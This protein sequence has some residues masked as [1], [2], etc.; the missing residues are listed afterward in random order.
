[1]AN[2]EGEAKPVVNPSKIF[3]AFEWSGEKAPEGLH[4]AALARIALMEYLETGKLLRPPERLDRDYDSSGGAWVSLRSQSNIHLRHARDGFWHF[5]GEPRWSA[6]EDI[7]RAALLTAKLLPAGKIGLERLASSHI[8][9][10]SFSALEECTL[11]QLD[12]DRYGI[13]VCS[14]ERSAVMGGALPRMPGIGNEFQ[15]FQ[16]ARIANGK[17]LAIEPYRIYRHGV[18]KAVEPGI[19]W[20]KT[21]VPKADR[22]AAW[23]NPE[24]CARIAQ[25]ARDIAI[26]YLLGLPETMTPLPDSSMLEGLH[27]LFVT[28]YIWGRLRG[29]MGDAITHLDADL[30]RLVLAALTDERFPKLEASAPEAVAVS[31]SLLTNPITLGE[32]SPET[33][34]RRSVH[35]MQALRVYQ[36]Q[37]EGM[38]LPFLAAMHDLNPVSYAL[39][40]ID[41]AG[42]TRPPY[43][44]QRFDCATW[45]AD[46]EG[47]G[48]MEGAFRR[49]GHQGDPDILLPELAALYSNYIVKHQKPDG[50]FHESYEP[51]R[52][53]LHDGFTPRLASS[54][55]ETG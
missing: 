54:V 35:G 45:L 49:I 14:R 47:A 8:A 52:N 5:P 55:L 1:M 33:V 9:V 7:A 22:P 40:V 26:S 2:M 13:V 24:L 51:F 28:I 53:R 38:L 12:N 18:N 31:I 15:Q 39:E 36:N 48:L 29:C 10:T 3:P 17:L 34:V 11:G 42:I 25:R 46:S 6:A 19:E 44:W 27:S 23:E 32:F 41:K 21:G 37:R 4:P 30:R 43:F 50:C 16:Q 20:Q